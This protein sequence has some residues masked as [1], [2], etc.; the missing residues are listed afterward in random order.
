VL[1]VGVDIVVWLK[2]VVDV[3]FL[4]SSLV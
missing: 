1:G 4:L 2:K 3:R